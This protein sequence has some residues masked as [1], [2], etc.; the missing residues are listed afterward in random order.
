MLDIKFA[1]SFVKDLRK[2]PKEV[3]GD[4]L[5]KWIPRIQE[6]PD[7][8]KHFSGKNLKKFLRLAFRYKRNNY[9]IVYQVKKTEVLIVFLAIGSRENFYKKIKRNT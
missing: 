5:E 3:R 8:G 4:V 7:I 1:K 9:R 6:S 2:I